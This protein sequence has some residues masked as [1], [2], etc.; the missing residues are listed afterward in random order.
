M[1]INTDEMDEIR[2]EYEER[3]HMSNEFHLIIATTLDCQFR[4]FY[5][6]ESH[7]EVYMT[8]DVKNAIIGNVKD[9]AASGKDISVVWYGGEPML[10]FE[11]IRMFSKRFIDICN[12]CGVSYR[13]SMISNGYSFSPESIALLDELRIESLQITLDG[14][15]DAHEQRRPLRNEES[16]FDRIVQNMKNIKMNTNVDVHLRINVDKSNIESAYELVQYCSSA[17]LDNIDIN[18]GMM[19]AFG[20]DHSCGTATANLFT[21]KEFAE[22]FLNLETILKSLVLKKW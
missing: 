2:N 22:E 20:C 5:C 19:K 21:M 9:Y 1:P 16:S 13:A 10:D 7:P 18:L 15:K 6:Y 3:S 11:S 8:E 12:S 14:M 17:G 4:C